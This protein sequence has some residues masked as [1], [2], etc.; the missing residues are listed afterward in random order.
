[1]SDDERA[2]REVVDRWLEATREGDRDAV[3]DLMTDDVVFLV[4]GQEP[5]G[6]QEFAV[7]FDGMKD[8]RVDGSSEIREMRILGDWAFLRNYLEIEVTGP[9]AGEVTSRKGYTL[10]LLRKEADGRWRVARDANLV[11]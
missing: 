11:V 6:K 4:S 7:A 9:E 3:L 1:M 5:F 8:V 2:L 10:T